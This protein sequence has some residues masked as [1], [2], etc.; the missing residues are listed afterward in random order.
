MTKFEIGDRV[1][2]DLEYLRNFHDYYENLSFFEGIT[3]TV[4]T[5][6]TND[7]CDNQVGVFW[8]AE[9]QSGHDCHGS[10]SYKFGWYVPDDCLRFE[11]SIPVIDQQDLLDILV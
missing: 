1:E 9:L 6:D 10:C 7:K 11:Q 5:L 2:L 4:C 8:D 3:G